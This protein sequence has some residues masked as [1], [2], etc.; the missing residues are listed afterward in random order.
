MWICSSGFPNFANGG[1]MTSGRQLI[2]LT[3]FYYGFGIF[4]D[5]SSDFVC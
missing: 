3:K 5:D 4:G 2:N 1:S